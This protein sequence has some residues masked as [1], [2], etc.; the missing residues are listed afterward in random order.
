M[1][2]YA[3]TIDL[4]YSTNTMILSGEATIIELPSLITH[5]HI[6]TI[7][8]LEIKYPINKDNVLEDA[9]NLVRPGSHSP[10][11]PNL[12]RLYVSM[13]W[14]GVDTRDPDPD[15]L[16]ESFDSL[17]R[18]MH[19]IEECAFAI[20]MEWFSR[21]SWHQ[22]RSE[23]TGKQITYS[24]FWRELANAEDGGNDAHDLPRARVEVIQLPY[25]DS[26]PKPP[27]HLQNPGVGYWIL[28]ASEMSL[29]ADYDYLTGH[30]TDD[31]SI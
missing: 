31:Y 30:Y 10:G 20:P 5:N 14:S 2:S 6:S 15:E 27:H 16:I 18:A 1:D 22:M 9:L 28:E 7:T 29:N 3:E 23:T 13:E 12:R 19:Q 17:A 26:Y 25:V 21:I 4:L 8:A 24:Q 11:F